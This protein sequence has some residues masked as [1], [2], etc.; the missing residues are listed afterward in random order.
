MKLVKEIQEWFKTQCD[1]EWEHEHG[2]TIRSLDNPGWVVQ[3]SLENTKLESKPFEIVNQNVSS[4]FVDQAMGKVK[5]PFQ[6][7][8]PLSEDWILCFVQNK[9]FEGAGGAES[10]GRILEAFVR[11]AK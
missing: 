1:G 3:I 2:L 7:A 9:T 11:W 5:T 8:S 10:L 6:C 4:E